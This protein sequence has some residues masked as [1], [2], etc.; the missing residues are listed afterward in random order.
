MQIHPGER[1]AVDEL[2][3]AVPR[4]LTPADLVATVRAGGGEDPEASRADVHDLV[5]PATRALTIAA[6]VA[7]GH[8]TAGEAVHRLLGAELAA[9]AGYADPHAAPL[10]GPGGVPL[11]L[12]RS[13]PLLTP[14]EISRAQALVD[15]CAHM[16]PPHP[17]SSPLTR[18]GT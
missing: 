5:D 8:T 9:D 17:S 1:G 12:I 13:S 14:T 15:L 11:Y 4:D 2:L 10:R 18:H 7:A 6:E 16:T 3:V